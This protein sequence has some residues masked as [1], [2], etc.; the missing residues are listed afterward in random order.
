MILDYRFINGNKCSTSVSDADNEERYAGVGA[1][2]LWEISVP[3]TKCCCQPKTTLKKWSLLTIKEI[4][5]K[6]HWKD[7]CWSGS[8]NTLATRCEE[9]THW[10]RFWC[11]ERLKAG[12]G[13]N[14]GWDG[15]VASPTTQW[16]WVWESCTSGD[17]QGSPTC[18]SPWGCK[19]SNM[20]EWLKLTELNTIKLASLTLRQ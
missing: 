16:T 7:W 10:K 13:D 11:G 14:R 4:K 9:L 15:C 18:C 17:G 8:S 19:E 3:C 2:S 1:G 12:E 6:I 5:L 20:K